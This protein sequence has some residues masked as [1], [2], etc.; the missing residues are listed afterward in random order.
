MSGV[1]LVV[2]S[3]TYRPVIF[4]V[5]NKLRSRLNGQSSLLFHPRCRDQQIIIVGNRFAD[6]LLKN[7]ILIHSPPVLLSKRIRAGRGLTTESGG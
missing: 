1:E 6:E 2:A 4:Q 7:R 3:A 5:W